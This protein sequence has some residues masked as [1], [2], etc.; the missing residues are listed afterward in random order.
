MFIDSK[1]VLRIYSDKLFNNILTKLEK[2][3]KQRKV[4]P[5]KQNENITDKMS[6]TGDYEP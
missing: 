5:D 2:K 3:M 1:H 4:N 6:I